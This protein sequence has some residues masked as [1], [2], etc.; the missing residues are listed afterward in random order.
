MFFRPRKSKPYLSISTVSPKKEDVINNLD[1]V[2]DKWCEEHPTIRLGNRRATVRQHLVSDVEY[3]LGPRRP[4]TTPLQLQDIP[5]ML[6]D[7]SFFTTIDW[8]IKTKYKAE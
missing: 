1:K 4:W 6:T 7:E 3:L 5:E 8:L 2:I